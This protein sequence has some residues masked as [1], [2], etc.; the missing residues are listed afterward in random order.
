M[1]HETVRLPSMGDFDWVTARAKCNV[2]DTFAALRARV[3]RDALSAT[4]CDSLPNVEVADG[5]EHSFSASI[6][7][8]V[9]G[10]AADTVTFALN[11]H[12]GTIVVTRAQRGTSKPRS[13]FS[14]TPHLL[15]RR[16]LLKVDGEYLEIWD[17]SRRALEPL[18]FGDYD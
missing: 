12:L 17:L 7:S 15:D 9:Q 4:N 10:V 18:I 8:D 2:P 16:C 14:A 11:K 6:P 13:V 3:A 5:S 1:N